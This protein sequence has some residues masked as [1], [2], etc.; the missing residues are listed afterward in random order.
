VTPPDG[1]GD[2]ETRGAR[3]DRADRAAPDGI[4]VRA[5][6]PADRLPAARV[7]DAAGLAHGPLPPRIRRGE[8][9]VAVADAGPS[10]TGGPRDGDRGR[11]VGC[12]LLDPAPDA[13]RITAVAVRRRRRGT[14]I[15]TAL[16]ERAADRAR[17]GGHDRLTAAFDPNVRPFYA[18]LGFRIRRRDGRL[19]GSLRLDD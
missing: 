6:V 7:L 1:R 19:H 14:G 18:A 3:P 10:P 11:V 12:L 16:A 4:R 2:S 13:L 9:L 5:A 17:A 15:G 8:L